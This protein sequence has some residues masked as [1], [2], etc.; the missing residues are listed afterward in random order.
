M[1][2]FT[3]YSIYRPITGKIELVLVFNI[4]I[5]K[6]KSLRVIFVLGTG[7]YSEALAGLKL[8]I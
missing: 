2:F 5:L 6:L 4:S 3:W 7:S 1:G 8:F